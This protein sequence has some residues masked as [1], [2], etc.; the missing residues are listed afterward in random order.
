MTKSFKNAK[1]L[2]EI[3][4]ESF[5]GSALPCDN[6]LSSLYGQLKSEPNLGLSEGSTNHRVQTAQVYSS[7]KVGPSWAIVLGLLSDSILQND[8]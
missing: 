8:L 6:L 4:W 3:G 5:V 2:Q 1:E 7:S